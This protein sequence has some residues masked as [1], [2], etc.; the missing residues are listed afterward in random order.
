MQND[1]IKF[2]DSYQ[3]IWNNLEI[4]L[5]LKICDVNLIT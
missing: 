3:D 1:K 5:N 2:Q 4:R